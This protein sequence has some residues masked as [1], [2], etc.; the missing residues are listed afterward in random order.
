MAFI[1]IPDIL[2]IIYLYK[3]F[4]HKSIFNLHGNKSKIALKTLL[5]YHYTPT[6][7]AIIKKI[8]T[9]GKDVENPDPL[10]TVSGN[11]K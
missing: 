7:K 9:L 2:H 10:H 3:H 5:R 4:Y 11:V 6:S 1:L 8:T